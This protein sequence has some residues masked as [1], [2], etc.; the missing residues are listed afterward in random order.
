V[1]YLKARKP[2]RIPLKVLSSPKIRC[3]ETARYVAEWAGCPLAIEDRLDEQ[4]LGG[5]SDSQFFSRLEDFFLENQFRSKLCLVSH[6]DVLPILARIAGQSIDEV[7]KG[8]V[9]WIEN[10]R[11]HGLNAV[12]TYRGT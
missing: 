1:E 8:D 7:K 3:M 4:D 12:A 6:G 2:L 9:Y 11:L 10:K 5:E